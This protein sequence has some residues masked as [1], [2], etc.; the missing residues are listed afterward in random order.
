MGSTGAL[1]RAEKLKA[2]KFPVDTALVERL[3]A[4]QFPH[5]AGLP[6]RPVAEDGWDN[7]TFR[8]GD[9]MKVRLPSAEGYAA[10][11]DKEARW[12]PR[13]A[14]QLPVPVPV[15]LG[16]GRP[17]EGFP[18]TWS[19]YEWIA[20]APATRAGVTDLT[21]F[22]RDVA[23]VLAALQRIDAA[24]GPPPG[25]HNFFRGAP[26]MRIYEDEARRGVEALAGAIDTAAAHRLLDAARAAQWNEA[27]VWVHG[28]IAV[29]NLLVRHGRLS[30]V[31]DF[32]C[33]AVGDP[34]CDLVLAWLFLEGESRE[35]FRTAVAADAGTWV[36][37][38][39]W[40]LWKAAIVLASGGVANPAEAP[41]L[42]VIRS[43]LAEHGG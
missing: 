22:A 31:I 5:W 4:A 14:P 25:P 6:V 7:W 37:A 17:A 24:G 35:A 23:G 20:G 8:L 2:G 42:A 43:V 12:L 27:P 13:L 36:R 26:P 33:M 16:V 41:P 40:A 19:V 32:G 10:Q 29:G 15:P 38:R 9:T 3:V 30:A 18:W 11:A 39:A 21:R 28:D 1:M 34:A